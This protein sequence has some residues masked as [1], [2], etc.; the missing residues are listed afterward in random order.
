[1]IDDLLT[2]LTGPHHRRWSQRE[3]SGMR[4]Y[5]LSMVAM[6][7]QEVCLRQLVKG[8]AFHHHHQGWFGRKTHV[9]YPRG[10]RGCKP[11]HNWLILVGVAVLNCSNGREISCLEFSMVKI[12]LLWLPHI[13]CQEMF[14]LVSYQPSH[15]GFIC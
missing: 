5:G 10:I 6:S 3:N 15:L 13:I 9:V 4:I 14:F 12:G 11:T 2:D 7:P 8:Q 1:M